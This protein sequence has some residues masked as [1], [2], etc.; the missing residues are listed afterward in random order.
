MRYLWMISLLV[1]S[2]YSYEA[3]VFGQFGVVNTIENT[4]VESSSP[5]SKYVPST[6]SVTNTSLNTDLLLKFG[7][8]QNIIDHH[9]I[10]AYYT[11]Y[12]TNQLLG[13]NYIYELA[14]RK[15]F[16]GFYGGIDLGV[17]PE[18]SIADEATFDGHF[19]I[20]TRYRM[21]SAFIDLGLN[22]S[23]AKVKNKSGITYLP[24]TTTK[25]FPFGFML[26]VGIM[27][28]L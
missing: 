10:Q 2:A 23:F 20:G 14:V 4:K 1:V 22:T 15:G 21:K 28:D 12:L 19:N 16:L 8:E 5:A 11:T 6:A 13:V 27:F 9:I 26:S 7:Y 24:S 18:G 3:R 17:M 25:T